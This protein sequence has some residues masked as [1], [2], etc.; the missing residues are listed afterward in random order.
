MIA[1]PT[2]PEQGE[3]PFFI[4]E[5]LKA[6]VLQT[7]LR[8]HPVLQLIDPRRVRGLVEASLDEIEK[9]E[10]VA[11]GKKFNIPASPQEAAK[12]KALWV[13]SGPG[14]YDVATK[15][16][17]YQDRPWARW[18]DRKRLNYAA[19]LTR[20]LT[21]IVVGIPRQSRPKG[22]EL[23]TEEVAQLRSSIERYGPYIIYNGRQDENRVV[24]NVLRREGVMI[25]T[26][27]VYVIYNNIDKTIDQVKSFRLPPDIQLETGDTIGVITHAPHM[28]RLMHILN[29][30]KPFPENVTVQAFPL[31]SPY[32]GGQEH[33]MDEIC[34]LLNYVFVSGGATEEPYP[35]KL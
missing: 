4:R 32:D 20:K 22:K 35:Y 11:L 24:E 10:E 17:R 13:L 6:R 25:P 21:E 30:F 28:M 23:M 15:D 14:T 5:V 9:L 31:P 34:G 1:G 18:M 27:K 16:D 19:T 33:T 3:I 12:I 8:E 26:G 7:S 29:Y 2:S